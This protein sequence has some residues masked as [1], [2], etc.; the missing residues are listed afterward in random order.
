MFKGDVFGAKENLDLKGLI[1]LNKNEKT[2][3]EFKEKLDKVYENIKAKETKKPS[4]N[5]LKTAE[6]KEKV[7]EMLNNL[8]NS[9]YEGMDAF[10][11]A[12]KLKNDFFNHEEKLNNF[13]ALL[14]KDN[15]HTGFNESKAAMLMAINEDGFL[16]KPDNNAYVYYNPQQGI[17][18]YPQYIIEDRLVNGDLEYLNPF[19]D[20]LPG[21][22]IGEK[23]K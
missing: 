6:F 4:K 15:N 21:I 20:K 18:V 12:I 17:K 1:A 16:E 9:S 7:N 14:V 23:T 11:Y 13:A 19:E 2:Q 22:N 8:N 3:E 5:I 10:S